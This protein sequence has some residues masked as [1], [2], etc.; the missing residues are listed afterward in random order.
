MAAHGRSN[1][2][3]LLIVELAS[4]HKVEDA[5]ARAGVSE[6]TAFRRL[7]DKEFCL[8]IAE[9]RQAMVGEAVGEAAAG[10]GDAVRTLR[11]LSKDSS[12]AIRLQA[13]RELLRAF[14]Q[15]QEAHPREQSRLNY[16]AATLRRKPTPMGVEEAYSIVVEASWVSE[17]QVDRAMEYLRTRMD[18]RSFEELDALI[19]SDQARSRWEVGRAA[20]KRRHGRTEPD[21][22]TDSLQPP[23]SGSAGPPTPGTG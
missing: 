8:R 4:G 11:H 9:V 1:A 22:R 12:P 3:W 16:E 5:A 6:R 19:E 15:L 17:T 10:A 23:P 20:W 7:A 18:A 14:G 21:D 2:D 13:A